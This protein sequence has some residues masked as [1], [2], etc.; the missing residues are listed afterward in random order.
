LTNIRIKNF[1]SIGNIDLTVD[2]FTVIVGKSDIGK[3][4][5]IRAIDAALS[6]QT[7]SDFIRHG[8]KKTSVEIDYKD[9]KIHWEKGDTSSYKVN[10]ESFTKLNRAVPKPMVDA[11]FSKIDVGDQKIN[12]LVASQFEPLF[13]LDKQGS[14]ITEV[15]SALYK[16]NVIS[17]ADDKCQKILKSSK[18]LFKTRELDLESVQKKL[19]SYKDF[20]SIKSD[21]LELAIIEK[22]CAVLK[23]EIAGIACYEN[24]LQELGQK[25]KTLFDAN[26]TVV[27][28]IKPM[29]ESVELAGWLSKKDTELNESVTV[30]KSL[31]TYSS[32]SVPSCEPLIA[33]SNELNQ[34]KI[35]ETSVS[36]SVRV[37]NGEKNMPSGMELGQIASS[38]KNVTGMIESVG[39]LILVEKD[40]IA[41]ATSTRSARDELKQT[42]IE[43]EQA[44]EEM[45]KFGACPLCGKT[46]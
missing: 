22:R 30:V 24:K 34:V 31:K 43:L 1:Q 45:K 33:I 20:D 5:V 3:S 41:S 6:N 19:E 36:N 46:L 40:F 14:V 38:I 2:G 10:G 16:L 13:L 32:V 37:L 18:T 29:V 8:Q 17:T 26:K 7:G 39:S 27:P 4:A 11:G 23:S 15:L 28:D 35:W 9:L 25:L 21:V 42:Q 12:P 44:T